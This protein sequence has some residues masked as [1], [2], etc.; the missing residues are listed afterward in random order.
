MKDS[1]DLHVVLTTL[2]MGDGQRLF[3]EMYLRIRLIAVLH[4]PILY[5]NPSAL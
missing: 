4:G 3:L 5:A 1:T 2:Y